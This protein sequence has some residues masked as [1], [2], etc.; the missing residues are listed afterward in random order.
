MNAKILVQL[1]HS[2]M[3]SAYVIKKMLEESSDLFEVHICVSTEEALNSIDTVSYN[4][5]I[6][7]T[8]Q[9]SENATNALQKII[10][11]APRSAVLVLTWDRQFPEQEVLTLGAQDLILWDECSAYLLRRAIQYSITRHKLIE[12]INSLAVRDEL[13]QLYNR[14][15]FKTLTKYPIKMAQ[16]NKKPYSILFIDIDNLKITND[17]KGYRAGDMLITTLADL[18]RDVFRSTDVVSRLGGDEFIVFMP[19]TDHEKG[20]IVE[21]RL[22]TAVSN[23]NNKDASEVPLS[24]SIGIATATPEDNNFNELIFYQILASEQVHE[25]KKRKKQL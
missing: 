14:R 7:C 17:T 18:L 11:L 20:M 1:I 23:Q 22:R 6:Y 9:Y 12:Q 21:Q 10:A 5:I 24:I 19:E 2:K 4:A 8:E 15:G 25:E 16:R 13:T 3:T